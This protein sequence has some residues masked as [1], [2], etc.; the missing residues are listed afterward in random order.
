M[1]IPRRRVAAAPRARR[2]KT[3]GR[4]R[5]IPSLYYDFVETAADGATAH[6]VMLDTVSLCG[7]STD[8]FGNELPG[9]AYPGPASTPAADEQWAWLNRTL[10]NSTA[11]Y[12]I[13][14]GHYP[15]LSICEHGPT[16]LL[17]DS[18]APLLT[19][20]NASAYLAG[21][22]HCAERATRADI[23]GCVS[24]ESRRRRGRDADVPVETSRR[25]AAAATRMC[26]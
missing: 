23:D 21:H 5:Y 14:T 10:A 19:N 7:D 15:I 4:L 11:D 22:D 16:G 26:L 13:V 2:G 25:D 18:L 20:A 3:G 8:A 17:E 1:D 12:L 9:R 24:D 6:F